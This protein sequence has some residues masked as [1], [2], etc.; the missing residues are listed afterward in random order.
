[1]IKGKNTLVIL[2]AGSGT[3]LRPLTDSTPKGMVKL[4]DR[5]LIEQLL[6]HFNEW[7]DQI[8]L[9]TGYCSEKIEDF[10][11]NTEFGKPIH[12]IHNK[13]FDVTNSLYSAWLTREFWSTSEELIFSNSDV[14]FRENALSEFLTNDSS[15]VLSVDEKACD[16]EDMK[17]SIHNE[18]NLVTR[19]SKEIALDQSFGEF[20]GI[21]KLRGNGLAAFDRT[22]HE[23]LKEEKMKRNGWYDLAFNQMAQGNQEIDF[24]SLPEN[25]YMEIDTLED[26]ADSKKVIEKYW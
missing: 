1:M 13:N 10:V 8:V 24:V 25:S 21:S 11:E 2:A 15:I 4:G 26:L 23:M 14:V 6:D 7:A 16:R 18:T 3:R 17:V 5:S 9:V 19:V 22:I 20:T 12:L